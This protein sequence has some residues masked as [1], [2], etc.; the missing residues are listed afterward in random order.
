MT[1]PATR[2]DALI[3]VIEALHA[4][5]AALKTNDVGA[6][7]RATTDKL[8]RIEAVAAFGDTPPG[9]E[10]RALAQEAQRLNDTCRI[11]VN[12]MAANVR[13]RLQN[14]TGSAGMAMGAAPGTVYRAGMGLAAFA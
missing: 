7:E 13:R 2:R 3:A 12:L 10:M 14:L 9:A 11:Y 5:I 8:M 6:L 4:E 1:P